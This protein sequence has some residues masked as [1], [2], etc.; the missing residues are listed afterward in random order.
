VELK[1]PKKYYKNY[2]QTTRGRAI[3]LFNKVKNRCLLK[4]KGE[5]SIDVDWIENKLK[6]GFCELSGLPFDLNPS[7]QFSRNPNSPS[8]DRIDNDNRDYSPENTRLILT[9]LNGA[10]NEYGL[11]HFLKTA[12][13]VLNN[14]RKY[15]GRI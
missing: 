5:V 12:N 14:Q 1:M 11:E 7:T 2:A 15:H 10:I 6:L 4:N 9:S 13:A 3:I 8:L